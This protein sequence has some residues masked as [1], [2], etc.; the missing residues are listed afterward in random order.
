MT[1]MSVVLLAAVVVAMGTL[2]FEH[3][4]PGVP[5]APAPV[6]QPKGS[7]RAGVLY[8]FTLAFAPTAKESASRHL[9]SYLAGIG[10]HISV[11]TMLARLLASLAFAT[12]PNALDVAV[13]V[14]SGIG[15]VFGLGL[16]VKRLAEA[17]LARISVPDDFLSNLLVDAAFAACLAATV[18]PALLPLFQV[19][20][21]LLLLYM[22]LGKLRHMVFLLSS[23]RHLGIH[24]GRR[25]VRPAPRPIGGRRG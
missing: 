20:G 24:F 9:P 4:Q 17:N 21:A 19:T 7:T 12:L 15:L 22:P 10:F 16:L 11:F 13:A 14:I 1:P 25:G 6:S 8:A 2:L 18:I 23:R 5:K 3:L